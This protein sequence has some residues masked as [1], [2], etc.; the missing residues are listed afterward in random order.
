[1][2]PHRAGVFWSAAGFSCPGDAVDYALKQYHM[3]HEAAEAEIAH[4]NGKL[5]RCASICRRIVATKHVSEAVRAR[6][7]CLLAKEGVG[8]FLMEDRAMH[9]AQSVKLWIFVIERRGRS[10]HRT[11]LA[12]EGFLEAKKTFNDH[13]FNQSTLTSVKGKM[14]REAYGFRELHPLPPIP[15]EARERDHLRPQ[16]QRPQGQRLLGGNGTTS[17]DGESRRHPMGARP[18]SSTGLT[19]RAL[20]QLSMSA[21]NARGRSHS[22]QTPAS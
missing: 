6:A 1:M 14:L 21:L 18:R 17:Q 13:Y 5:S 22:L 9:A 2:E 8:R 19:R 16:S 7:H 15:H 4:A 3:I 20:G 12:R 11:D 10:K